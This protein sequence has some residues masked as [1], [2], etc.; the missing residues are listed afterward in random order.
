[1]Y[2]R[3]SIRRTLGVGSSERIFGANS[4]ILPW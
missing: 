3:V 1:M 2:M 4:I